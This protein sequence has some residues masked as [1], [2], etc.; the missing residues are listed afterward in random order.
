MIRLSPSKG[1]GEYTIKT[2][3]GNDIMIIFP[4]NIE[5]V[6]KTIVIIVMRF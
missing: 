5:H 2:N 4:V 6:E 1:H 3:T